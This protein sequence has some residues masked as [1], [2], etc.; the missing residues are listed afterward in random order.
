MELADAIKNRRSVRSFS[1]YYVTDD[2]IRE[3]IEAA[4]WAPS[5]ANTQVWEFV[6]MRERDLIKGITGAFS[7][8]NPA[9]QCSMT[10]SAI[11]VACAKTRVSGC[12]DGKERTKF[13][14]WFMFDLG[15]AVQNLC[16]RACDLDLGTVIV[17]SFNHE[18]VRRL[19]LLPEGYEAVVAIPVGRP[20]HS[21][22]KKIPSRKELKTFVHLDKFGEL[23]GKIY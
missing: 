19:L 8:S 23:Y 6:V 13:H 4:R 7:E 3:I 15:L 18:E 9:R 2:E 16:L 11:I 20:A 10:A 5:W 12:R 22:E 14:E 17:G 21:G 1:D